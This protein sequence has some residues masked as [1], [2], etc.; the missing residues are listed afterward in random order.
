MEQKSDQEVIKK[1]TVFGLGFGSEKGSEKG[2]ER[3]QKQFTERAG[4]APELDLIL[5]LIQPE[6]GIVSG[7]TSRMQPNYT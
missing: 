6:S 2:S 4:I 5:D 7:I 3:V 1:D